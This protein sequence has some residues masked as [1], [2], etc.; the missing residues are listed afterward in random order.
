[1]QNNFFLDKGLIHELLFDNLVEKRRSRRWSIFFKCVFLLFLLLSFL[2]SFIFYNNKKVE[3]VAIVDISGLISDKSYTNA[4]SV[5]MSLEAAFS[6]KYSKAVILK[7]NSPGG[8][9]VQSNIIHNHIKK[10][11]LN[12]INKPVY[13]VIEDIGTSG[14]YLIAVAAEKIYC[15]PFSIVGSI[16]VL[17]NSFGFSEA[18]NKLGIERRV[19]KA[20]KNKVIMDPFLEKNLDDEK[21][22][23][24]NLDI[25]H[26]NFINIV[27]KN[28]YNN[29]VICDEN[30]IFSGKF[31]VGKDALSLGLV[32]GFADVYSLASDVMDE[33]FL[34]DYTSNPSV[35][36]VFKRS[37][38]N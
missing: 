27:K 25:L 10:L 33:P 8:T 7:I 4:S 5:I 34:I 23:Q 36:S 9:P 30:D 18:I 38:K 37:I 13:A 11:R 14:A 3:H 12:Y 31:W 26:E 19:Y 32:D 29:S 16:G 17:V 15:D 22:L 28:R 6:N 20:G 2:F 35:L 1:M 21:I 24:Y